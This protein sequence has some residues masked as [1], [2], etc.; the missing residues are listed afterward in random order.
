MRI[1]IHQTNERILTAGHIIGQRD[2]G[3]IPRL[4]DYTF[5][6]IGNRHLIPRLEEHDRGAAQ[7]RV[8]GRPGV[9]ADGNHVGELNFT[10]LQ[11]LPHHVAGHDFGQAGWVEF[12]I[13]IAFCQHF[14]A[15]IV[16][17]YPGARINRR[18]FWCRLF[19]CVQRRCKKDQ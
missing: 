19:R 5:V 3:I 15:G 12:F 2:A 8:A 1:T 17:Q 11:R 14:A 10:G 6:Q 13:R 4:N 16:H 9:F 7:R 18:S